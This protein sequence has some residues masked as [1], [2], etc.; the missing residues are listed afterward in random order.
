MSVADE[1]KAAGDAVVSPS[2]FAGSRHGGTRE[3]VVV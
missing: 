2:I 1:T 3:A